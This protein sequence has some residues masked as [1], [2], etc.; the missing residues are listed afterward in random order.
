VSRELDGAS[1]SWNSRAV[2]VRCGGA[3]LLLAVL[4]FVSVP[5]E[6]R[7]RLCAFYWLTGWPCPLC[8]LTR[9]VFALAKGHWAEAERFN[10]LTP[11]GFAM[12]FSLFWDWKWR[13]RLWTWGIAAFV[14]YGIWRVVSFSN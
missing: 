6:P 4:Y 7:Y 11:L 3:A 8:G 13:A 1:A 2:A 14:V 12:M 5:A 9:G 10:A